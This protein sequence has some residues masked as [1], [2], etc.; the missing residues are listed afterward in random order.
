MKRLF[1]VRIL[2]IASLLVVS[3]ASAPAALADTPGH[4]TFPIDGLEISPGA[5]NGCGFDI[6]IHTVGE[7]RGNYW[8]DDNGQVTRWMEIYGNLKQTLSANG[9]TLRSRVQGSI[10]AQVVSEDRT[11]YKFVGTFGLVTV[12][13]SGISAGGGGQI[14]EEVVIDVETGEVLSDEI[15]KWVGST[16]EHSDWDAICAYLGP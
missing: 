11:L 14:V 9:K 5:E 15:L 4:E 2:M 6:E 7:Y 12:P 3:L 1:A 16:G 10:H 13:G 8:V